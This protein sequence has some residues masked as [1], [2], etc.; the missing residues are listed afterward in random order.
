MSDPHPLAHQTADGP[1]LAAVVPQLAAVELSAVDPLADE[2]RRRQHEALAVIDAGLGLAR[3][4]VEIEEGRYRALRIA[5]GA[6]DRVLGFRRGAVPLPT[7]EALGA[8][9]S[10]SLR[11]RRV[12]VRWAD[13]RTVASPIRPLHE[14]SD[15]DA[16]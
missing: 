12:T 2:W 10:L 14:P 15:D 6:A 5:L 3:P 13:G 4:G 9:A 11:E 7:P 1:V 16:A 8:P